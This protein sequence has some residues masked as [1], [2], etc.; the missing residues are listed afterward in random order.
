MP[1]LGMGKLAKVHHAWVA[2][3]MNVYF[4]SDKSFVTLD[5]WLIDTFAASYWPY[6]SI[7]F[8]SIPFSVKCSGVSTGRWQIGWLIIKWIMGCCIFPLFYWQIPVCRK[9]SNRGATRSCGIPSLIWRKPD[10]CS[11]ESVPIFTVM[12]D[13]KSTLFDI[14][15]KNVLLSINLS[16]WWHCRL[17]MILITIWIYVAFAPILSYSH[18]LVKSRTCY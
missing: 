11:T 8:S 7:W 16:F 14:L 9:Y 18:M 5:Y 17:I 2:T 12:N 1:N 13:C 3:M 15:N 10:K 6:E 4:Y